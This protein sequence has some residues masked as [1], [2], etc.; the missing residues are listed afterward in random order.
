[1]DKK[2]ITIPQMKEMKQEGKKIKMVTAYDYLLASVID[3]SPIE[4]ILVGDSLGMVVLGYDSTVSVTMDDMLHHVKPVVKGAPNTL[5]IC[6][7]PFGSYNVS[8]SEAIAN[9]NRIMKEGGADAV[10]LEGGETV[11]ETVRAIVNAGIP[12]MAHIG[13]TPQTVSQL[14]GF[15]VQGKDADA[16]LKLLQDGQKLEEAGA[17]AIVIECVPA[18]VAKLLTEKLSIP[19]IGIGAGTDCDGQVLVAQDML[20][21]FDRFVPKFVKQYA[22]LN[23]TIVDALQQYATEVDSGAFPG[24]EHSFGMKEEVLK[25]LY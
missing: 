10:K 9:A 18:P 24:P 15:K 7:M 14:G 5:V 3:K 21:M 25:K 19:V 1:M 22:N 11:V 8:I 23:G 6:D 13:L 20:G 2:K 4:T 17:F 12:V 16:A